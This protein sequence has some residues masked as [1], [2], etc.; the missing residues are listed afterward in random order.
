MVFCGCIL[1]GRDGWV[2][3]R[4]RRHICKLCT[5]RQEISLQFD[6]EFTP[7]WQVRI[8]ANIG[9]GKICDEAVLP[10][11]AQKNLNIRSPD[12]HF[13]GSTLIMNQIWVL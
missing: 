13:G 8:L 1:I 5:N 3:G 9:K 10:K 2:T 11:G 12:M 6:I 7:D 4:K